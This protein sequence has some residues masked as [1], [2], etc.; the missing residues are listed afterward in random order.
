[1]VEAIASGD[2]EAA[3]EAAERHMV[4]AEETLLKAMRQN[5]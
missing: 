3:R 2:V 5:L 1:M 4:R